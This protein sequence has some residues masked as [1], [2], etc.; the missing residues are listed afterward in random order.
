MLRDD[1]LGFS[2]RVSDLGTAA[3]F[4]QKSFYPH[5]RSGSIKYLCG[6]TSSRPETEDGRD[7]GRCEGTGT[8]QWGL[9]FTGKTLRG[10]LQRPVVSSGPRRKENGALCSEGR[11]C[12]GYG[13]MMLLQAPFVS[14]TGK[15]S[16]SP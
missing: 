9:G 16:L 8:P 2:R 12:P 11:R 14:E 7:A 13:S 1:I 15:L 5:R 3:I 4:R 6:F 10:S